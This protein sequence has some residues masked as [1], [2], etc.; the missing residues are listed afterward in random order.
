M[1]IAALTTQGGC[2]PQ[3]HVHIYAALNVG[4]SPGE[5][6]ESIFHC[7]PYTGFLRVLNAT[8]VA[9]RIFEEH[10]IQTIST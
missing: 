2:E 10:N 4:L 3:L 5:I 7:T 8:F 1:T 9:K 6:V